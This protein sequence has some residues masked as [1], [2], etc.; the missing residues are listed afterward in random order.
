VSR[1]GLW[2]GLLGAPLAWLATL[3]L[4]FAL[5]P[6]A[7]ARD[8]HAVLHLVTVVGAALAAGAGGLSWLTWAREPRRPGATADGLGPSTT[9]GPGPTRRRFLGAVGLASSAL[10]TLAILASE[11]PVIV[12]GA[13]D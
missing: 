9:D 13:C 10:F 11:V 6:W 2:S 4:G 5:A 7:C 12:L 3:E 1:L 8:H